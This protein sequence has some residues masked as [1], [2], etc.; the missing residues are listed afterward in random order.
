MPRKFIFCL[1]K[2]EKKEKWE[3]E[4]DKRLLVS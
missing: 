3:K 1:E 4:N 2:R